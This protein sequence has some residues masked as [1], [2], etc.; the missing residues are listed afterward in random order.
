[1]MMMNDGDGDVGGVGDHNNI[2]QSYYTAD[3]VVPIVVAVLATTTPVI[4]VM[5]SLV[6]L[7]APGQWDRFGDEGL[8]PKQS[9]TNQKQTSCY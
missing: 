3:V 6:I 7:H 5:L 2:S 4:I 1:M 9:T 8:G